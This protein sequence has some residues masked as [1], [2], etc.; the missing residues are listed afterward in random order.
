M[1]T[2]NPRFRLGTEDGCQGLGTESGLTEGGS[3][4]G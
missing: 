2:M 4:G 1:E 3:S